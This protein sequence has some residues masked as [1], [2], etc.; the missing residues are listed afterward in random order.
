MYIMRTALL[1]QTK[2]D[3]R[4][5]IMAGRYDSTVM[6]MIKRRWTKVNQPYFWWLDSP[7]ICLLHNT[8]RTH[9]YTHCSIVRLSSSLQ[10]NVI[11]NWSTPWS[12]SKVLRICCCK[13]TH[14]ATLYCVVFLQQQSTLRHSQTEFNTRNSQTDTRHTWHDIYWDRHETPDMTSTETDTRHDIYWDRHETRL[15]WHLLRQ[16]RDTRHDIY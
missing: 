9:S 15:T 12:V 1:E 16:T 14:T 4:S 13:L 5:S 2:N 7:V 8:E 3:F 10:Q 6:F 11:E